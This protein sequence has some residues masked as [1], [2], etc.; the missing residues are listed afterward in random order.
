M[1]STLWLS[2]MATLERNVEL[3]AHTSSVVT[4]VSRR[5]LVE[6]PEKTKTQED[7]DPLPLATVLNPGR[8]DDSRYPLIIHFPGLV[9]LIEGSKSQ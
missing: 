5:N 9:S 4:S 2:L 6:T 1:T 8:I 7:Q 3:V